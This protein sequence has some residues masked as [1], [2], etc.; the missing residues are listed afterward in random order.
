M[1]RYK[2]KD[3]CLQKAGRHQREHRGDRSEGG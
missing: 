3:Y 1:Y 2:G